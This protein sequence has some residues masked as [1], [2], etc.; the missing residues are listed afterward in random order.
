MKSCNLSK[1][2]KEYIEHVIGNAKSMFNDAT[3]YH[4]FHGNNLKIAFFEIENGTVVYEQF[5]TQYFPSY[6]T[7]NYT[8]PGYMET[9]AAQAFVNGNIYGW[10]AYSILYNLFWTV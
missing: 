5:C 9:F 1:D 3:G 4:F 8:K 2:E 6:L 10:N 7:E